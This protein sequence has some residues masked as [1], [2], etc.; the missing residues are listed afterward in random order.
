M[1]FKEYLDT[2]KLS[3][4]DAIVDGEE[5]SLSDLKTYLHIERSVEQELINLIKNAYSTTGSQ[6]IFLMGNVGDGKSHLLARMWDQCA[7]EMKGF[8]V[9]NDATESVD[10]NVTYL[11]HLDKVFAPYA[12]DQLANAD[13]SCKTIIA[14]NLGT[15]TNFLE[16]TK[17]NVSC[18]R[19]YIEKNGLIEKKSEFE[20]KTSYPNFKVLNLADYHIFSLSEGK[21]KCKVLTDILKKITDK[22]DDNPFYKAYTEYYSNHPQKDQCPIK[23]NYDLISQES[24]QERIGELLI[25]AV[26]TDKLIVSV[27]LLMN[28]V[29]D[30]LVSPEFANKTLEEIRNATMSASFKMEF[31]KHILPTLLFESGNTSFILRSIQVYDP[32]STNNEAMETVMIKLGSGTK[33]VGYFIEHQ[34]TTAD[35][36]LA[37]LIPALSTK[38]KLQLFMRLY[39]MLHGA[40]ALSDRDFVFESFIKNLFWFNTGD[41]TKLIDVYS[42]VKQAIFQWNGT[43]GAE[44]EYINLNIGRRQSTYKISQKLQLVESP[45]TKKTNNAATLEKFADFISVQFKIGT[46]DQPFDLEVDYNLYRLILFINQGYRPN[47]IDKGIHI[48][49]GQFVDSLIKYESQEKELVIQ[50][51]VGETHKKFRL[52]YNKGFK[53]FKF[54]EE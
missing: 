14:I 5:A 6:I 36:W 38:Q 18:M 47:R 44:K 3:S 20:E 30:V 1:N 54:I 9:F 48:K 16:E 12:D 7:E 25:K 2:L 45:F 19:D 13:S 8:H 22:S 33:P 27:R 24:V 31:Y 32:V 39:Y 4:K 52:Q 35:S 29:F 51:F 43:T 26:L 37:D 42:Q 15:L 28:L 21:A 23:F 11:Q 34:L 17:L 10:I 46:F 50:E 41:T 53:Y 49:F 40:D